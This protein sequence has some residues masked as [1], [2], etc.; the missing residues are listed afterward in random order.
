MSWLQK[1]TQIGDSIQLYNSA[2]NRTVLLV[3]LGNPGK[4]YDGTRHNV[5]FTCVEAFVAQN[6]EMEPW[7]LKKDLKCYLSTGRLGDT[8]VIAMKPTTFMN[9]SGEAVQ[10]VTS[11][12]KISPEFTAVV[13]D[14]LDIDFGQIRLRSGGSSAG[15]NGLKSIIQHFGE[16]FG[17]IRIGVGP[18]KPAS[19]DS[20]DF[21]LQK[22]SVDEQAQL[23]NLNR[24]VS[25][26]LSEYAYGNQLP[27][28]TRSFLV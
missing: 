19:I 1:R 28:E 26:I 13:H 7:I 9:L 18:K 20:A 3:G 25:A 6:D 2:L 4:E 10:A 21:V 15:H 8:R 14:D 12:Y 22:F 11:F 23:P 24:E 27:V 16:D 17:R 5:G